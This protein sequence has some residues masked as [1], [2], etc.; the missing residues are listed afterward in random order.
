MFSVSTLGVGGPL[1]RH[2]GHIRRAM[3]PAAQKIKEKAK[4]RKYGK[5]D[6]SPHRKC[7]NTDWDSAMGLLFPFVAKP[8]LLRLRVFNVS[9]LGVGR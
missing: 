5:R 7:K 3:L 6:I 2:G 8:N 1:L 9:A 4:L